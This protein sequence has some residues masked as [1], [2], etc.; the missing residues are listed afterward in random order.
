MRYFPFLP[1]SF[2]SF[3]HSF[4]LNQPSNVSLYCFN[5]ACCYLIRLFS[6]HGEST[7]SE[8]VQS[9]RTS[10]EPFG[11]HHL[12][13]HQIHRN[14]RRNQSLFLLLLENYQ[15]LLLSFFFFHL[16]PP[17]SFT[18]SFPLPPP[19]R[20]KRLH[21]SA[22][23][24]MSTDVCGHTQRHLHRRLQWS[25]STCFRIKL[26]TYELFLLRLPF[27][28][29]SFPFLQFQIHFSTSSF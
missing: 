15:F 22:W 29:S 19:F 28:F 7:R 12:R 9:G 4:F 25:H 2:H 14:L 24:C 23:R 21:K 11:A 18:S 13:F 20:G 6:G 3:I 8:N 10:A 1:P 17:F 5:R 27:L 16:L 26:A